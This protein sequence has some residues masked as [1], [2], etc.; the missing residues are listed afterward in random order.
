MKI[1]KETKPIHY[2]IYGN[3]DGISDHIRG[4]VYDLTTEDGWISLIECLENQEE[5]IK[6]LTILNNHK[7]DEISSRVLALQEV[8]DKYLNKEIMFKNDVDPNDA[9][10]QVL[11]EL[12]NTTFKIDCKECK[13]L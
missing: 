13:W 9:V 5:K 6:R 2:T 4:R 12:L 3:G 1:T 10:Q 8:A 11:H 7:R